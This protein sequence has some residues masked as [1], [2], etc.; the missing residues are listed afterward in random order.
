MRYDLTQVISTTF[1]VSGA[2]YNDLIAAYPNYKVIKAPLVQKALSKDPKA[3]LQMFIK[4]DKRLKTF[5]L[6]ITAQN[7]YKVA[8]SDLITNQP[9]VINKPVVTVSKVTAASILKT[10]LKHMEDRA[11]TYDK[12]EGE[13]SMKATV[14]A[15]NAVTG[16]NLT[17]EQGW[18]FMTILKV[19]RSQQGNFKLDN[20]EDGSAYFGLAGEAAASERM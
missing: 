19:V 17:K 20:Y 10:G 7:Y 16:H 4:V 2:A 14:E 13:R 6:L 15:F 8:L 18:H 1:I 12:P 9:V 5:K 11:T 3:Y